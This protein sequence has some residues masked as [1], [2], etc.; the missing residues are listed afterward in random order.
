MSQRTQV[1][2]TDEKHLKNVEWYGAHYWELL[3]K[4][5]DKWVAILDQ[6]VVGAADDGFELIDQ[7]RDKGIPPSQPLRRH[8]ATEPKLLI[9][10]VL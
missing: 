3:E 9:V 6:R 4:Y 8:L 2:L 1:N 10:P 5:P 7:L